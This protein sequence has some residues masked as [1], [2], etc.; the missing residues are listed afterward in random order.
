MHI[1]TR[2]RL[3]TIARDLPAAAVFLLGIALVFT[4]ARLLLGW[5]LS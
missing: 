1:T 3:R 4:G 2:R 5:W